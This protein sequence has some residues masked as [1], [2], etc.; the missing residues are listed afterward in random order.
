[1]SYGPY[2]YVP[3]AI[4]K[5]K[6]ALNAGVAKV[7][8]PI[9]A[10][11]K[12]QGNMADDFNPAPLTRSKGGPSKT[13]GAVDAFAR[14]SIGTIRETVAPAMQQGYNKAVDF[15]SRNIVEPVANL[16]GKRDHLGR[17]LTPAQQRTADIARGQEGGTGI[18]RAIATGDYATLNKRYAESQT[19]T[20]IPYDG[21]GGSGKAGKETRI[22]GGNRFGEN[23][24]TNYIVRGRP[25]DAAYALDQ[26]RQA[27]AI[28]QQ[29]IDADVAH[30]ARGR[31]KIQRE[32]D[33]LA[34]NKSDGRYDSV[35]DQQLENIE[36]LQNGS[37]SNSEGQ[38]LYRATQALSGVSGDLTS[39]E[40][41]GDRTDASRYA[42]DSA[43]Y[44]NAA[45][46]T[47]LN[48]R[49]RIAQQRADDTARFQ[50]AAAEA[51]ATGD[52]TKFLGD[53]A[54]QFSDLETSGY[55]P[56]TPE[57]N[58]LANTIQ[59][60][61]EGTEFEADYDNMLSNML[62]GIEG[63]FNGG[64]VEQFAQGGPV[65]PQAIPG[66]PTGP[67][68]QMMQKY[69]QYAV[70]A[71]EMGLTAVPFE[72]FASLQGSSGQTIENFEDGG[73]IPGQPSGGRMVIDSDPNAPVDSIPAEIDG[74]RPAALDSGEFI[75]PTDVV[76]YFGT[77]KLN[78]MIEKAR[79]TGEESNGPEQSS[80]L[81]LGAS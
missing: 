12:R 26:G 53:I 55:T 60:V 30:Q 79:D 31:A 62:D 43:A 76:L 69:Q 21:G 48:D 47:L 23:D 37:Y 11:A 13:R 25:G 35:I 71:Q 17:Q 72:K 67:N 52:R 75:F 78:K 22:G 54:T 4:E 80:A 38:R 28:R 68:P 41:T 2:N 59:G 1:M 74:E 70:G 15:T 64:I 14:N 24:K 42:A 49:N 44:S 32:S 66:Q 18:T 40:N 29:T 50:S 63:N 27:N 73:A 57:F 45:D 6:T 51:R 56:G 20:L 77:D 46:N 5:G 61:V 3:E 58:N 81:Q 33:R 34:K 9:K 8:A 10:E 65:L 36:R 16:G 7:T 39:R 19:G